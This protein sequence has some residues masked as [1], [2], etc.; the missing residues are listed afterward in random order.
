[1]NAGI[2]SLEDGTPCIA[3]DEILPRAIGHVE[4][5][6]ANHQLTLMYEENDDEGRV[7]YEFPFPLDPPFTALLRER[8][9]VAVACIKN[10]KLVDIQIFNVVFVDVE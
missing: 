3:Y 10:K 7:G 4:F 2:V 9:D 5:N 1:M 8:G 6:E